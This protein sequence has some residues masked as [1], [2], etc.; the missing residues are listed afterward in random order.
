MSFPPWTVY[1]SDRHPC[2][3]HIAAPPSVGTDRRYPHLAFCGIA[4]WASPKGPKIEV[5]APTAKPVVGESWCAKCVGMALGELG[6]AERMA[7]LFLKHR[8]QP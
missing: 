7:A 3:L 5:T 8:P 2:L 6:L 4:N 1:R